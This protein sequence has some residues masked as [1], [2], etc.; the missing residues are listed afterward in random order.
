MRTVKTE[1]P[2]RV[3]YHIEEWFEDSHA[4]LMPV[5]QRWI[6]IKETGK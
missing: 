6:E 3:D 1:R 4:Q 5:V 2:S